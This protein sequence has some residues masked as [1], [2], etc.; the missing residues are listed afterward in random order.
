[1]KQFDNGVANATYAIEPF[2]NKPNINTDALLPLLMFCSSII[3]L[4][5]TMSMA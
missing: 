5:Y 1:M 2:D 3:G 4:V